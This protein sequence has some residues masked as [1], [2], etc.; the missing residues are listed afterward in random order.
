MK[1]LVILAS[2]SGTNAENIARTFAEGGTVKVEAL[3]IDRANAPVKEKMERLGIPVTYIPRKE[4][5]EM[6]GDVARRIQAEHHPDLI[7][8]AGFNSILQDEFVDAFEG[9]ILNIHPSLLPAHG[10][11]GM[12]GA[13]VHQAVLDAG[14][15]ES[16]PTVHI[17]TKTVDGG[18][19]LMQE[20]VPVLPGDTADTLE[21]R[22]HEAE[23][24]LYPRAILEMLRRLNRQVPPPLPP[25]V[26]KQWADALG[27]PNREEDFMPRPEAEAVPAPAT[28][29]ASP[30][31]VKS[32]PRG[33]VYSQAAPQAA[34]QAGTD[35]ATLS[36]PRPDS[37]KMPPSYMV[38][39]ILSLVLCC[40]PAGIVAVIM[41]SQ[42]SSKFYQGDIRGAQRASRNA[43]IWIIISFVLGVMA[44]TLYLPFLFLLG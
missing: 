14:D 3:Y 6:P 11:P 12:W 13:N 24:R 15:T 30:A 35:A 17:V 21:Q 40:M 28:P 32:A 29:P 7:I 18:P 41:S 23:Y 31:S 34:P 22:V 9:R 19:I 26:D 1:S 39:A 4:W 5:R 43:E 38:W 2:G 27:I 33:A 42:V 10:G 25:N 8:L 36:A 44:N 16:G 37:E 20:R